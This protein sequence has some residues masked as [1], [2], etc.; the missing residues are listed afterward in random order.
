MINN[1]KLDLLYS[2]TSSI[3]DILGNP[4]VLSM[5]EYFHHGSTT[6]YM[7]CMYVSLLSYRITLFLRKRYAVETARAAML[8]DFFLYDWHDPDSHEGNHALTHPRTALINA[9]KHFSL[10]DRESEIILMHM[11]PIAPR[12]P[13]YLE[14]YI[15]SFVDTFCAIMDTFG[16][17]RRFKKMYKIVCS[18]LEANYGMD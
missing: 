9:R 12:L 5:K 17:N 7:H 13:R 4:A 3:K 18:Q 6:C 14:T 1:K 11:W 15:V 16:I 8:H 2:Y 10:N